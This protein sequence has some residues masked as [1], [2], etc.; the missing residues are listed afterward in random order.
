MAVE[1]KEEPRIPTKL[2][3][4]NGSIPPEVLGERNLLAVYHTPLKAPG[5]VYKRTGKDER[6]KRRYPTSL[7]VT[8]S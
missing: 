7:W 8:V 2:R 6:R 4:K 1:K 3:T 5:A